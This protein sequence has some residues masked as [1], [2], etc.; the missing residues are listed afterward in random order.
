M[1]NDGGAISAPSFICRE[2]LYVWGLV[3]DYRLRRTALS[4]HWKLLAS[5]KTT[6]KGR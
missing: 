2:A 5:V 4:D 3:S 1:N 6:G